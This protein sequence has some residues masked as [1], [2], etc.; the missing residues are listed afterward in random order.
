MPAEAKVS[1]GI[2]VAL[3][4]PHECPVSRV[5]QAPV[6]KT[7]N[8][9]ANLTRDSNFNPLSVG[10]EFVGDDLSPISISAA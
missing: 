3:F 2:Y 6:C 7:V 10:A 4:S 1:A 9:S 8:V 5:A